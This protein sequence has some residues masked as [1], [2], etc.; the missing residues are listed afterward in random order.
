[1]GFNVRVYG[2]LIND[3]SQVLICDELIHGRPITKFPGGGLEFGE[4]TVDALK[5][6]MMEETRTEVVVT[7][8]F[9]TTDFFQVSAFNP[10]SQVISIYYLIQSKS[11]LQIETS[12]KP[13]DFSEAVEGAISFRWLNL[14]DLNEDVFT[15]PI[16]K[17]VA[18]LL[19]ARYGRKRN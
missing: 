12:G 13:F 6:E 4:G 1:M 18:G 5:R 9:Y 17:K 8:H 2:L 10:E 3:K 16:D 19:A 11:Y 15:F 7:E 14:S